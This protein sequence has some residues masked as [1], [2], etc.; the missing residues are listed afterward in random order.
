MSGREEKIVTIC[1]ITGL[2]PKAAERILEV[3]N[4]DVE[5][6]S[7]LFFDHGFESTNDT[8]NTVKKEEIREPIPDVI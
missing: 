8:T 6:A 5:A 7:N 1:S 2:D 3:S 4:W